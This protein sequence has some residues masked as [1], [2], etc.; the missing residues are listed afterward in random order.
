MK[1]ITEKLQYTNSAVNDIQ[2]AINEKGIEVDNTIEL[3]YYGDKIREIKGG[4][5]NLQDYYEFEKFDSFSKVDIQQTDI[6]DISDLVII[7]KI[8]NLD[9]FDCITFTSFEA[10][11]S[12]NISAK[13]IEDVSSNYSF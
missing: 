5:S 1:T 12:N 3:G 7:G 8:D 6:N 4:L 9:T 2:A 11:P 13:D 10:F